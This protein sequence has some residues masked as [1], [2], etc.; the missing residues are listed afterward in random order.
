MNT[1]F[2]TKLTETDW[3]PAKSAWR[4]VMLRLSGVE[5]DS[6]Y[7]GNERLPAG[8]YG[9]DRDRWIIRWNSK[10]QQPK[11]IKLMVSI[12]RTSNNSDSATPLNKAII[13]FAVI[14]FLVVV[15]RYI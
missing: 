7:S 4:C 10:K 3:D 15:V 1:S 5:I 14:A 11:E 2:D 6:I 12:N 9:I 13:L 8:C